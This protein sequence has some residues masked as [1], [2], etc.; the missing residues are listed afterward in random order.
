MLGISCAKVIYICVPCCISCSIQAADSVSQNSETYFHS[1]SYPFSLCTSKK[2]P[3]IWKYLTFYLCQA[4][5]KNLSLW[6]H[7]LLTEAEETL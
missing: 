5:L 4:S 6:L 3:I 2:S 7:L 1:E